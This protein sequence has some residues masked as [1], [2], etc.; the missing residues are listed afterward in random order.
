[1]VHIQYVYSFRIADIIEM[2]GKRNMG[3]SMF[4]TVFQIV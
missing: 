3:F 4:D 1:M 2:H